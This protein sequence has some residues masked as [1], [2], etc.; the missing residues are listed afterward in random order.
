V[1]QQVLKKNVF[2]ADVVYLT[3]HLQRLQHKFK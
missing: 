2:D 1:M 3:Q